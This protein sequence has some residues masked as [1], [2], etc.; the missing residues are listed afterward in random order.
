M[1][2]FLRFSR[3]IV[4]LLFLLFLGACS[5]KTEELAP[6][7]PVAGMSWTVDG[8]AITT[9][10]LQGQR[11]GNEISIAG[12]VNPNGPATS[13]L[14]LSMPAAVGT[15]TFN[16]ATTA[17][18]TYSTRT[19]SGTEAYYAGATGL[20][21]VTGTGSIVVTVLTATSTS[22]TFAFTGVNSATGTSK[23]ITSGK[24]TVGL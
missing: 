3:P 4:I 2:S 11:S 5:S 7:T 21:T 1:Q 18:G 9:T 8:G 14:M 15:Y 16:L 12:T 17:S 10:T 6:P 19:S 22:G 20:G 23:S 13:Y 24:F